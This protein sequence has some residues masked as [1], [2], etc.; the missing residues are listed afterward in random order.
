MV[1][2]KI[3]NIIPLTLK[4]IFFIRS[5]YPCKRLVGLDGFI[6][7]LKIKKGKKGY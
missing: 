4:I 7:N 5:F 6:E 1:G 2:V 3:Q